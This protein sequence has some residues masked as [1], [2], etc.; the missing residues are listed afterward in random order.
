MFAMSCD[1]TNQWKATTRWATNY[2]RQVR[3]NNTLIPSSINLF[4]SQGTENFFLY[5]NQKM[6]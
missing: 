4:N 5:F 1:V 3:K 6:K 2:K